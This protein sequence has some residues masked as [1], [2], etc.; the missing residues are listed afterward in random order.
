MR[1]TELYENYK[2]LLF[3]LAY[4]LTGSVA[5]AE[6]A[7]QD[8]FVKI[9]KLNLDDLQEPKAYLCKM[10]TNRCLDLLKSAQRRREQYSGPWL[11]ELVPTPD[12]DSFETVIRSDLLS[13]A[14]LV[15]LER[16][17]PSE[18]TIF[19]LRE[20]LCFDYSTIAEFVNKSETNCRKLM[21]RAREKMGISE[22]ESISAETAGEEWV[23]RFIKA[24][25]Q[26]NINSVLSLL[27]EDVVLISDGG[28]KITAAAHPIETPER[29]ARFLLGLLQKVA[30]ED[31]QIELKPLNGQTGLIVRMNGVTQTVVLL[32]VEDNAISN[33]YFVRNPDKLQHL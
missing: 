5:D 20:A 8:V 3:T 22:E 15:L 18:R 33:L 25:T 21:S 6:D 1:T 13:Y 27:A 29:V 31:V 19:V 30:E 2:A 16:L 4:Q 9:Y 28:G 12:D 14:M 17:S 10:V 7:V 11:P 26:N 23:Q 24:L 32:H